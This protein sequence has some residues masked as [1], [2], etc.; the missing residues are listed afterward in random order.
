MNKLVE[1]RYGPIIYPDKDVYIGRSLE[2]YGEYS[3]HEIEFLKSL[4]NAGDVVIDVGA[5]IGA[6]TIP[7]A[8]KVGPSGYLVAFEPQQYIYYI[9]CGNVAVNNILNTHVFQRV[10]SNVND[11]MRTIPVFDFEKE[12]NFV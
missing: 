8:Q 9:L 10:V 2:Q 6:L 12:G 1:S 3:Y 7:L 5:N 11:Q 4:V